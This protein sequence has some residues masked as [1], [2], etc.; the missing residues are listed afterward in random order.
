MNT[1]KV[2]KDALKDCDR[3]AVA[4]AVGMSVGSLNNQVAGEHPYTP[5][6]KTQ[7]LLER[8]YNLIDQT[9]TE[10][11]RMVIMEALAEEFGFM[12]IRNPSI[13]TDKSP[14]MTQV[15]AM[16]KK[17]GA[18]VDEV[19]AALADGRIEKHEAERIR[20]EWEILKRTG[21]EFVTCCEAGKFE[22]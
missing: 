18:V 1:R 2:L 13:M 15:A 10:N 17:F 3:K 22:R 8:M 21:E 12:L 5:K 16:L 20:A 14:A 9:Y 7:N 11:G 6:G 4:D 19:G